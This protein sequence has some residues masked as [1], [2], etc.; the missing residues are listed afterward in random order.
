MKIA[1]FLVA[2]TMLGC[3]SVE[4]RRDDA[5]TGGSASQ[6]DASGVGGAGG[7]EVDAAAAQTGGAGGQEVDAG[8][9]VGC[10]PTVCTACVNGASTP[11]A[12]GTQCGGGLCDGVP[13]FYGQ[14]SCTATNYVCAAGVCTTTT[15]NCCSKLGCT[16]NQS[17]CTGTSEAALTSSTYCTTVCVS[18]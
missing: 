9:D 4:P 18:R 16:S 5:G 6:L 14:Y 17:A 7:Q 12:D 10:V 11:V 8:H 1:L 13:N 15:I 3:G 2:L